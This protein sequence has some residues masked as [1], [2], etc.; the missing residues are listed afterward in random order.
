MHVLVGD[1]LK[2]NIFTVIK[3]LG[4]AFCK[5]GLISS[6][7]TCIVLKF[8]NTTNECHFL[9][10]GSKAAPKF[11]VHIKTVGFSFILFKSKRIKE[12]HDTLFANHANMIQVYQDHANWISFYLMTPQTSIRPPT[13]YVPL[14]NLIVV[15]FGRV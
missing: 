3:T 2:I 8:V 11:Y 6:N 9:A 7:A 4:D 5:V 13:S 12:K 10:N 15:P 1:H 14:P